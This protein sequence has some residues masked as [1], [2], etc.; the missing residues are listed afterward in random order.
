MKVLYAID[1]TD[2]QGNDDEAPFCKVPVSVGGKARMVSRE[3]SR[4]NK[5]FICWRF[6][7]HQNEVCS[8]PH[9]PGR[10]GNDRCCV[11][12]SYVQAA[13]PDV[14]VLLKMGKSESKDT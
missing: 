12:D 6:V 8:F 11:S 14:N 3:N 13:L 4:L 10:S 2:I 1:A 9:I 7:D 5:N